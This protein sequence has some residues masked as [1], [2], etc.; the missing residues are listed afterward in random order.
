MTRNVTVQQGGKGRA[1]A[2]LSVGFDSAWLVPERLP[3][4]VRRLLMADGSPI[5]MPQLVGFAKAVEFIRS[6]HRDDRPTVIAL[7]QPTIVPN[8]SSMRPVDKVAA[9]IVSWIGGGV[10]PA[11]RGKISMFSDGAPI[12]RFIRCPGRLP[13]ILIWHEWLKRGYSW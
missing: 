3:P 9:S 5:S 13:R 11:N 2:V 6:V 1:A 8:A 10:Q 7:D 4:F 12:W